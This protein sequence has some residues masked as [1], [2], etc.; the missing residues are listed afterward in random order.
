MGLV[1]VV[2]VVQAKQQVD[3]LGLHTPQIEIL[4]LK[5]ITHAVLHALL[6]GAPQEQFIV[7]Q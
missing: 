1:F 7:K 2:E 5:G 3:S 6:I 4:I